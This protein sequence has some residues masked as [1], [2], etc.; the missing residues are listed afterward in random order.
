MIIDVPYHTA[1]LFTQC[2]KVMET[3]S[4]P[5]VFAAFLLLAFGVGVPVGLAQD[6]APPPLKEAQVDEYPSLIGGLEALGQHIQYPEA[7]K[8]A[9]VEGRVLV[10]FV[11]STEGAP[12]DLRVAS[13][14]T[15]NATEDDAGLK[16]AAMEAVR[17]AR[18]TPGTKAGKP[19]RVQMTLPITFHLPAEAPSDTSRTPQ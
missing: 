9:G 14:T 19:V 16:K 15:P 7:A 11:V 12:E 18:F 2:P 1:S 17:K 8:K 5:R 4:L 10:Q 6:D 3:L 13:F